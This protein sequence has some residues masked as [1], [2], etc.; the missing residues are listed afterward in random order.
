MRPL[1][2]QNEDSQILWLEPIKIC[3][4]I[5]RLAILVSQSLMS[6]A[7]ILKAENWKR[8][9]GEQGTKTRVLKFNCDI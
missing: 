7:E 6:V 5:G 1:I 4:I 9:L 2:E 8:E 3:E